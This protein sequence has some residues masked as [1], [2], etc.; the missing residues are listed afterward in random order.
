MPLNDLICNDCACVDEYFY[1]NDER[2]SLECKNCGEKNL[3]VLI[4]AP[5][6]KTINTPEKLKNAI[7]KRSQEDHKKHAKDRLQSAKERYGKHWF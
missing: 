6:L 4:S 1:S 2:D 3:S 7:K 5:G